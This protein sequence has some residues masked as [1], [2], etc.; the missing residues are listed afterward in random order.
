MIRLLAAAILLAFGI[1]AHADGIG[2]GVGGANGIGNGIG[3]PDG[4]PATKI[5]LTPLTGAIVQTDGT[6]LILQ[7]DG[8]SSICRAGATC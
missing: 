5:H 6:S 7:T 1:A 4:I 2:G 3:D 8:V